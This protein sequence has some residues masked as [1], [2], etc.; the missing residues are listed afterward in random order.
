MRTHI[1][2]GGLLVLF[3]CLGLRIDAVLRADVVQRD[4]VKFIRIAKLLTEDPVAAVRDF[5]QH[6]GYPALIAGTQWAFVRAGFFPDP[7]QQSVA[8]WERAGQAVSLVNGTLATMGVW[9][10]AGLTIGWRAAWIG[11]LLFCVGRKWVS[12]GA[13]VMS[14][15]TY[16]APLIWSIVLAVLVVRR[17]PRPGKLLPMLGLSAVIGLLSG[18]A[19]WVRPEG[20]GAAMV[21]VGLFVG[22]AILHRVEW[23]RVGAASVVVLVATLVTASPYMYAIGG[24]TK[25]KQILPAEVTFFSRVLIQPAVGLPSPP[26]AMVSPSI[27]AYIGPASDRSAPRAVLSQ[28]IEA[29]HPV[30]FTFA[31]FW[32][33]LVGL[34]YLLPVRY[35]MGFIP[36]PHGPGGVALGLM[37]LFYTL[38][39]LWLHVNAGYL[40][41]RHCMP[42]AF[43]MVPLAGAGLVAAVDMGAYFCSGLRLK[44]F[45]VEE[46]IVFQWCWILPLAVLGTASHALSTPIHGGKQYVKNA[47]NALKRQV[48]PGD[49][50]VSNLNWII[51][52]SQVNGKVIDMTGVNTPE[53]EGVLAS[54]TPRPR[55][56][57]LSQRWLPEDHAPIEVT[58]IP[59]RF[60]LYRM[61]RQKPIRG[62]EPD[63]IYIY[64]LHW[65]GESLPPLVVAPFSGGDEKGEE[66]SKALVGPLSPGVWGGGFPDGYGGN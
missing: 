12:L 27:L 38:I 16:L 61:I 31:C 41:W 32:V 37:G 23:G 7:S 34:R 43:V 52:Y 46:F 26:L 48:S 47:A 54:Q 13:D 25:K 14:D 1:V 36:M 8:S 49:Y 57:V 4:G 35:R 66:S 63:T 64:R 55:W 20:L 11:T 51:H 21:A 39:C 28:S 65:E 58:L 24:I 15:A 50:T 29:V 40:D 42:L 33:C 19:Y 22:W 3:V 30:V 56:F 53:I 45:T 17:L 60:E 18:L 59:P 44:R 10:L 6:T 9:V 2:W 62:E 5:H